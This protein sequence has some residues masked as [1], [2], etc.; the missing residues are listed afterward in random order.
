MGGSRKNHG[1]SWQGGDSPQSRGTS[2]KLQRRREGWLLGDEGRQEAWGVNFIEPMK[3]AKGHHVLM[4]R[5][6]AREDKA[7]EKQEKAQTHS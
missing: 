1:L 5:G 3:S 2:L 7:H 4:G 6:N